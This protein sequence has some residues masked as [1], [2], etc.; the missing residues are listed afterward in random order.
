[1]ERRRNRQAA[2]QVAVGQ[3]GFG[4]TPSAPGRA[5]PAAWV[6]RE[7]A[8][9]VPPG[10][11]RPSVKT[12]TTYKGTVVWESAAPVRAALKTKLPDGFEGQY[13][14]GVSGVPL[15]KVGF[16]G[17]DSTGCAS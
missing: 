16:Q 3:S 9:R 15:A 4:G 11:T 1:M 13:V 10:P 5:V 2:D 12:V 7:R 8:Y 17:R 14:L 6:V